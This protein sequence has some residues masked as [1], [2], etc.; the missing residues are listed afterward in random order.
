[1]RGKNKRNYS[2]ASKWYLNN[3][4]AMMNFI[5]LKSNKQCISNRKKV[6]VRSAF[7]RIFNSN[8][9][10]S[11]IHT[12]LLTTESMWLHS[13]FQF[14]SHMIM[15]LM[16]L[17]LQNCFNG[18]LKNAHYQCA[19]WMER[20]HFGCRKTVVCHWSMIVLNVKSWI[21]FNHFIDIKSHFQ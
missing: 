6:R 19:G 4:N 20:N 1:M 17:C 7:N 5:E 12:S 9:D 2:T 16:T 8:Y 14:K 15:I 10:K 18:R 3:Q 21:I 11:I 13:N